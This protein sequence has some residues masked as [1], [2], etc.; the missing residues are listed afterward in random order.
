M[1]DE[2]LRQLRSLL[3]SS[4]VGAHDQLQYNNPYATIRRGS[5][6]ISKGGNKTARH[7]ISDQMLIGQPVNRSLSMPGSRPLNILPEPP[8]PY[9]VV[10]PP[11]QLYSSK[12]NSASMSNLRPQQ[13][14]T[15]GPTHANST[16]QLLHVWKEANISTAGARKAPSAHIRPYVSSPDLSQ[17]ELQ[18]TSEVNHAFTYSHRQK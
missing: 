10:A 12:R 5:A 14:P 9:S 6:P 8:P 3:M 1:V 4:R 11:Q 16:R 15:M 2:V 17:E 13:P 7:F 18:F